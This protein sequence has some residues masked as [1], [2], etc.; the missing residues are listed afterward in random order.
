[1]VYLETIVIY[2]VTVTTQRLRQVNLEMFQ[3]QNPADNYMCKF[4]NKNT[5]TRCEICSKLTIKTPE[6]RQRSYILNKIN[7][8]WEESFNLAFS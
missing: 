2:S 4:N 8:G 5:K 1:M 7:A 3:R 6:Q